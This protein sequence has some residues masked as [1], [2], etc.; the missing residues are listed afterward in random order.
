MKSTEDADEG[1][2]GEEEREILGLLDSGWAPYYNKRLRRWYLQKWLDGKCQSKLIPKALEGRV[3]EVQDK[4]LDSKPDPEKDQRPPI[5]FRLQELRDLGVDDKEAVRAL[6]EEGYSTHDMMVIGLPVKSAF[7]EQRDSSEEG[8]MSQVQGRVRGEGWLEEVKNLVR[9]QVFRT[10]EFTEFF[11]NVGLASSLAAIKKSGVKLEDLEKLTAS[12][13]GDL[14]GTLSQAPKTIFRALEAY[15]AD[16]IPKLEQERDEARFEAIN[17]AAQMDE[18]KRK[19]EP[20][21]RLENMIYKLSM[22]SA[23]SKV[24][25]T[26]INELLDRWLSMQFPVIEAEA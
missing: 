12:K 10:R 21:Y 1:K 13:T 23:T 3:K 4:K 15:D 8:A 11:Y 24:D 26:V 20:M 5:D 17:L 25:P 14:M 16:M 19:M 2:E 7:S 6:H 22:L 18:L 9:Y